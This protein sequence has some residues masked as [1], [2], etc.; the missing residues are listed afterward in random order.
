MGRVFAWLPLT[1]SL[2]D[3]LHFAWYINK[4]ADLETG[5]VD[6]EY[7][8]KLL[9]FIAAYLREPSSR[10]AIFRGSSGGFRTITAGKFPRS[11]TSIT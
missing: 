4:R 8:E 5:A 6:S 2:W 10:L 7:R 1:P 3:L 9:E 11:P